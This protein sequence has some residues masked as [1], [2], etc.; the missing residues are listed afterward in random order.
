[1]SSC[2]SHAAAVRMLLRCVSDEVDSKLKLAVQNLKAA[3]A[4]PQIVSRPTTTPLLS[5]SVRTMPH[6]T[7][8]LDGAVRHGPV[9]AQGANVLDVV[10]AQTLVISRA[11]LEALTARLTRM[12]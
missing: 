7:P 3:H 8:A 9:Y 1:M 4:L 12:L 10:K 11:G 6:V 5:L 2:S